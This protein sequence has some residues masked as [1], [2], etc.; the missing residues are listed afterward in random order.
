VKSAGTTATKDVSKSVANRQTLELR[1]VHLGNKVT[2]DNADWVLPRLT[3]NNFLSDGVASNP[4]GPFA[5]DT[6]AYGGAMV[7]GGT[8]FTKGIGVVANSSLTFQLNGQCTT[9]SA[10]IGTRFMRANSKS[11]R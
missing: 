11:G 9:F 7:I 8:G 2:T 4:V 5:M 3:C 1:V 10:T 6:N